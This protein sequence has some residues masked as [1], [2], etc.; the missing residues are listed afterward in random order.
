VKVYLSGIWVQKP[1][2]V[3]ITNAFVE[4]TLKVRSGGM[5]I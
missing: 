1:V 2:K 3:Y 4:K 5:W